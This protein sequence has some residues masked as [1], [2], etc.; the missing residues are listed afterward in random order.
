MSVVCD[1][2][3]V[4]GWIWW[5]LGLAAAGGVVYVISSSTGK[6]IPA[7]TACVADLPEA[8]KARARAAIGS[9]DPAR[10]TPPAAG[11][12]GRGWTGA[13]DEPRPAARTA[14]TA[15]AGH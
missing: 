2:R 11:V 5:I 15:T 14:T 8:D 10:S 1:G 6:R 13:A 3:C 7:R 4:M 12:H 9:G